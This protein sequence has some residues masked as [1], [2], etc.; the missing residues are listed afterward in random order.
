[1]IVVDSSA[2]IAI[3]RH[4]PEADDFLHHR[5]IRRLPAF[6][7]NVAGDRSSEGSLILTDR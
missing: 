1:V 4:E 2:L 5:R 6:L 3:L 7:G